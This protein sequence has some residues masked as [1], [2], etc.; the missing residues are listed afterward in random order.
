MCCCR[1]SRIC[2]TPLSHSWTEC[3]LCC[4]LL[5]QLLLLLLLLLLHC[6]C[7]CDI[8][9]E[10]VCPIVS[11]SPCTQNSYTNPSTIQYNVW[12]KWL[13]AETCLV[14]DKFKIHS[15]LYRNRLTWTYIP[16]SCLWLTFRNISVK[17]QRWYYVKGMRL[18]HI[19]V[20][21]IF[22]LLC[23]HKCMASLNGIK[24]EFT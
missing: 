22:I 20:P 6:H 18:C 23:L 19:V 17:W 11:V 2:L 24:K 16:T 5:L 4:V 7:I 21:S 8:T 13:C 1:I 12:L 10:M 9:I 15:Y 3:R 14:R